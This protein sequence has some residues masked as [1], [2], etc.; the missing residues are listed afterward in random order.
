MTHTFAAG[1]CADNHV[2]NGRADSPT[3]RGRSI[4][5]AELT[6]A[7]AVNSGSHMDNSETDLAAMQH[8]R[9]HTEDHGL[10]VDGTVIGAFG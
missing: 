1:S 6:G 7:W 2:S 3:R 10:I 9:R 8:V 5:G 4:D